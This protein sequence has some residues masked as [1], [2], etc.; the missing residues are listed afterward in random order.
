MMFYMFVTSFI[1]VIQEASFL[2]YLYAKLD[3]SNKFKIKE[4]AENNCF[5]Q[6]NSCR[7]LI[8]YIF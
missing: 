1:S 8:L 3:E 5:F 2:I 4:M 7:L 6:I